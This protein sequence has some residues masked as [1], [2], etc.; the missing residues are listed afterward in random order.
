MLIPLRERY[1]RIFTGRCLVKGPTIIRSLKKVAIAGMLLSLV[2]CA[3]VGNNFS[4]AGVSQ[5]KIGETGKSDVLA[6]FGEP[7][8]TGVED[9]RETWTYGYYKYYLLSDSKTRDLV[10]RFD[11]NSKVVSYTFSSSYPQDRRP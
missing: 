4:V 5:L 1:S 10:V 8:R 7:W 3:T 11:G 9:G 2:G 6:L